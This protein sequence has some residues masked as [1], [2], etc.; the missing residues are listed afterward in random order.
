MTAEE[1]VKSRFPNATIEKQLKGRIKGLQEVYYLV[2]SD[3]KAHG[4]MAS[5]KSKSN[6]W[7][8]AKKFILEQDL[9]K[10]SQS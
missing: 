1:F 8:T 10:Q 9:K 2:R 5:G 4:Y 6:A 7:T 3:Y